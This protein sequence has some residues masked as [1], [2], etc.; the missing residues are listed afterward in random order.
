MPV[1]RR[2]PNFELLIDDLVIRLRCL[3][4]PNTLQARV[5]QF[6][7]MGNEPYLTSCFREAQVWWFS[8]EMARLDLLSRRLMINELL[9]RSPR[10][11]SIAALAL[12]GAIPFPEL[13]L[14]DIEHMQAWFEAS[15]EF[16]RPTRDALVL[17]VM[18]AWFAANPPKILDSKL[19][20]WMVSR[21]PCQ[22]RSAL[23]L[24]V[25]L[26]H[27]SVTSHYAPVLGML[28]SMPGKLN[29]R[30]CEIDLALG[31][32]LS[33]IWL[34]RPELAQK[35]LATHGA[36]LSRRSFRI[37]VARM[38]SLVRQHLTDNWKFC[39]LK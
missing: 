38:P 18:T 13:S 26:I 19:Q 29:F 14:S 35:W 36:A 4:P 37:A 25:G 8:N 1:A 34:V 5:H 32:L 21:F 12:L 28:D 7:G 10:E 9:Q 2:Q 33:K 23:V 39:R 22:V 31:W 20:S 16:P 6:F 27:Q 11:A 24:S 3:L 17:R 15:S 30:E